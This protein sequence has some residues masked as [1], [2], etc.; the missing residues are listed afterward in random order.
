MSKITCFRILVI[1]DSRARYLNSYLNNTSLN[2]LFEVIC[3][4][5]AKLEDLVLKTMALLSYEVNYDL[6]IFTGGINNITR[7]T[8]R[9]CKHATLRY[10]SPDKIVNNVMNKLYEGVEKILNVKS[11]PLVIATIPGIDLVKYSPHAWFRLLPLQP[12]LDSSIIEINRQIRGLNRMRGLS[13]INLAYPVHRCVGRG[14][15]Y[16]AHYALLWDGLH[17]STHLIQKWTDEILSYCTV[18]L[19]GV[20]HVQGWIYNAWE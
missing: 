3:I 8:Y 17:P 13:T 1:G 11:V 7:I 19:H 16:F 4:P 10:N 9:P 14:G 5:G 18:N 20:Q 12:M 15:K 2:L 6:I